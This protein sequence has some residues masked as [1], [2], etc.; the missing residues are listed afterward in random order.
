MLIDECPEAVA[1]ILRE[2]TAES[3]VLS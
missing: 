3:R 2:M 1:E